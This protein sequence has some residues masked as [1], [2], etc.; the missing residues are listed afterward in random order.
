[1]S[2]IFEVAKEA[3]VSITTV[4]R[5]LNG[6][7]DV[8]ETTRQ[9]IVEIAKALDY[10]PSAVARNLQRRR[11]DTIAFAPLISEHVESE[12]FFKEFLGLLTLSAFHHNLSLL[13]TVA[14]SPGHSGEIYRELAGSGR[15]DGVILADIKPQDERITLLRSLNLPFVS[16][17]RT[18]DYEDLAYPFVDVDNEAGMRSVVEYLV[19]KG[20]QRIA[21]L[22]AP[23]TT[24]YSLHRYSG[25]REGMEQHGLPVDERLVIADLQNRAGTVKAVAQLLA[26][27]QELGDGRVQPGR[28]MGPTAIVAANDNLALEVLRELHDRGI[29]VGS[30]P[31]SIAV[32]GFDDLPFAEYVHPTLTTVR[33]PMAA[34]ADILL[35]LLVLIVRSEI[36]SRKKPLLSARTTRA[37]TQEKEDEQS[38]RSHRGRRGKAIRFEGDPESSLEVGSHIKR[39]GPMQ[40]LVVPELVARDSA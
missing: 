14:D 32:T 26:V 8:N 10:Y 15:V 40:V 27:D 35:D 31:G 34:I 13:A 23:F 30:A 25:F 22:G 38:K 12:R 19:S 9:R 1:M 33:Q 20:H 2:T 4:S 16:F 6:Y 36:E 37:A 17:G 18:A 28:S 39:V 21:Y 7:S 29:P 11:T 24:S 3:G 5:A